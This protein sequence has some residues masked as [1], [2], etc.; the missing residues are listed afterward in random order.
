[1]ARLLFVCLMIALSA[2]RAGAQ[3]TTGTT[4]TAPSS[5]PWEVLDNSFLVEEAFNQEA[6]IFQN[7][8][9]WQRDSDDAWELSFTQEWPLGG[10]THQFS[11]TLPFSGGNGANAHVGDVLLNYR[12]QL[13][14]E[15]A[16]IPAIAPRISAVLP[17]SDDESVD[18][19]GIETSVAVSKQIRD[20]Y[21]HGNAG[22]T[23]I[24]ARKA[25]DA[26][27]TVNLVSPQIA[28]SI[29]WRASRMFNLM[30]ESVA[31]FE[32]S[33]GATARPSRERVVTI[34]PG[35]RYGWN[36]GDR[37]IVL[38]A[39]VPVTTEAGESTT[40]LFGYASYE[41]PFTR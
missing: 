12:Y 13:S 33:L 17:T 28:G 4:G 10:I 30:L 37:Q 8:F 5:E 36:I 22:F 41:L 19:I 2:I 25:I 35:F 39:A 16:G 23:W 14:E 1:M 3:S 6:H 21:V 7:S 40:A 27:H 9:T 24:Q 34:S 15:K 26:G 29:I 11:Y 18:R 32:Q 31:L 38:G 20:F